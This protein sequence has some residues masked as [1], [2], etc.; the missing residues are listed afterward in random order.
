MMREEFSIGF[1]L[2][3]SVKGSEG[4]INEE[5]PGIFRYPGYYEKIHLVCNSI[6]LKNTL[7]LTCIKSVV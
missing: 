7:F 2:S 5:C 3:G 6:K 4:A 1:Y